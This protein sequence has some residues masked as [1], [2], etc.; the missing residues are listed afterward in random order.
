MDLKKFCGSEESRPYLSTP[1]TIGDWSYATNGHICVRVPRIED[2]PAATEEKL[3]ANVPKLFADIP[4]D[5]YVPLPA[6]VIEADPHDDCE[7]CDGRGNV[8]DC[9]SCQ[10]V[11]SACD[12]TGTPVIGHNTSVQIGE[13]IFSGRYIA[14][15]QT[16][17]GVRIT[18]PIKDVGSHLELKACFFKFDGGE[19]ALMPRRNKLER[20]IHT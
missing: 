6:V 13:A 15:I 14:Q 12:G 16:M 1:F 2:V 19:G 17:P 5:G 3:T 8:H 10:C 9:P 18:A 7:E 4:E 11:C 20:H